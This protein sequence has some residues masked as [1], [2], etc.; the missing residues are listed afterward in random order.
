MT[1]DLSPAT[2]SGPANSTTDEETGHRT[3]Y[4]EPYGH[5]ISVTT[6]FN[7]IA[8]I[9]LDIWK[10]Q[11][12]AEAAFNEL[13]TV[14][15]ASR[16]KACENTHSR[17]RKTHEWQ[18]RCPRCP[19]GDCRACVAKW[20][21]DRH[22]AESARRS[23]EGIRVHDVA[24]WWSMHGEIRPH[25]DDIK[26]YV[27]A[28][29]AF[30][31]EYGLTPASFLM[32]EGTVI[33]PAEKYAGT[34]D[35]LLRF[36]ACA[37]DSACKLVA[38]QL[39]F[40]GEYANIKTSEAIQRA[41]RRDKRTVDLLVDWK[42]REGEGA[43]FYPDQALQLSGY[44]WAPLVR[45]KG[46]DVDVPMPDTDGAVVVQLRP[47]GATARLAVATEQT[48]QGFLHALGLYT[49]LAECGALAVSSHTFTLGRKDDAASADVEPPALKPDPFAL[50]AAARD[51]R[52]SDISF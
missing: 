8:K 2:R 25:D 1:L 23:D 42:S 10:T 51:Q 14:I 3:Y 19:C 6:A 16:V 9:G 39:R 11:L 47:D 52:P 7:A 32:A 46:T 4:F 28:F 30:V 18:D 38:R 41:V 48:Y 50:I 5:L 43:S 34:C 12:T 27:T 35:G 36:D 13:P 20:L 37:T 21:A 33:N 44:R 40:N 17:C 29:L 26:P 22:F 24:E 31:E 49:W 15:T 45:I